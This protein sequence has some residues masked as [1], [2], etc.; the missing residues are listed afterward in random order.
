MQIWERSH[1]AAREELPSLC[2]QKFL[3]N[4]KDFVLTSLK[5]VIQQIIIGELKNND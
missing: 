5:L 3:A 2:L 4:S 1:P